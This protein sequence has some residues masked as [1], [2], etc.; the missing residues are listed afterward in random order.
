MSDPVPV[1]RLRV[2]GAAVGI[3]VL[4]VIVAIVVLTNQQGPAPGA[5]DSGS[6]IIGAASGALGPAG[7]EPDASRQALS[8]GA[9]GGV[10][11][12]F[13]VLTAPSAEPH[14]IVALC[15]GDCP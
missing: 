4:I 2:A 9:A 7:S 11:I 1:R 14:G 10:E 6:A 13:K 3:A 8:P 15:T 5:S 12:Q